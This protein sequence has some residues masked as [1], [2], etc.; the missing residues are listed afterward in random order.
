MASRPCRLFSSPGD[1]ASSGVAVGEIRGDS[2]R[3]SEQPKV[4]PM[5]QTAPAPAAA[6]CRRARS[7]SARRTPTPPR[8]LRC[9]STRARPD[10]ARPDCDRDD[11][12]TVKAEPPLG[13]ECLL[14][15]GTDVYR[16]VDVHWHTPSEHTV[17]GVA[18][19]R[20][21][22]MKR[23]PTTGKCSPRAT[24]ERSSRSATGGSPVTAIAGGS[25]WGSTARHRA[26]RRRRTR[27]R[28]PATQPGPS[29]D[30]SLTDPLRKGV[31]PPAHPG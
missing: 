30:G 5:S 18:F 6:S 9:D 3:P 23:S 4:F 13:E 2:R 21:Q 24:P 12:G 19:P 15:V 8:F 27:P 20:E 25:A 10:G 16:L 29:G 7:T 11:E 1:R 26:R 28:P 31:D 17:G 14:S 22:H